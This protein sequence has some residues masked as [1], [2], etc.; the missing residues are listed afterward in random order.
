MSL[1]YN[2]H[3]QV[4]KHSGTGAFACLSRLAHEFDQHQLRRAVE[5]H[6]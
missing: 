6:R 1:F 2:L 3:Q 5:A 4:M